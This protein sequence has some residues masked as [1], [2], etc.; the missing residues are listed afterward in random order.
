MRHFFCVFSLCRRGQ[1]LPVLARWFEAGSVEASEAKFLDV[2]LYRCD[3]RSLCG[4]VN[5]GRRIAPLALEKPRVCSDLARNGKGSREV[6][7]AVKPG[8][9]AIIRT[10]N[11]FRG[12]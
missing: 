1:E 11:F 4:A 6:C 7:E 8:T 2:I 12:Q 3:A 5:S 10:E 9:C